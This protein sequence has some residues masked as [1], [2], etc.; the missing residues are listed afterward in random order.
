ME[1]TAKLF[2]DNLNANSTLVDEL[3]AE[4]KCRILQNLTKE[5]NPEFL[6]KEID[7][8]KATDPKKSLTLLLPEEKIKRFEILINKYQ[9]LE[10]NLTGQAL[11][12]LKQISK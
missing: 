9:N 4:S 2:L 7:K 6:V 10:N 1:T 12:N 11:N 3:R 5:L 8:L